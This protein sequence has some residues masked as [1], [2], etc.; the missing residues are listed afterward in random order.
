MP[1]YRNDTKSTIIVKN[2]DGAIVP[3]APGETVQSFEAYSTLTSVS[4]DPES[5]IDVMVERH[6]EI[7]SDDVKEIYMKLKENNKDIFGIAY[8]IN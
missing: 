2:I 3:L 5:P 6:P 4:E 7:S 1:T 8:D